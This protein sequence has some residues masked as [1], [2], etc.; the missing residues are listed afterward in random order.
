M[1]SP[2]EP[3]QEPLPITGFAECC[4][5]CCHGSEVPAQPGGGCVGGRGPPS[6]MLFP[7]SGM[8]PAMLPAGAPS[9]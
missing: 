8:L 2:H 5:G 6:C 4:H 7:P 1:K 3:F 9:A